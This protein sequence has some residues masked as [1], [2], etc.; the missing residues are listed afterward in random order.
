MSFLH[1]KSRCSSNETHFPYQ[2]L[3]LNRGSQ[4]GLGISGENYVTWNCVG[5]PHL[6]FPERARSVAHKAAAAAAANNGA[7][8]IPGGV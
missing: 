3:P 1:I 5:Y 6:A 7:C 2:T 4:D 8:A